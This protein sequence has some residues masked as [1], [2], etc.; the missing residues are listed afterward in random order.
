MDQYLHWHHNNSRLSTLRIFRP[1][2]NHTAGVATPQEEQW[3]AQKDESISRYVA[4]VE[5]YLVNDFIAQTDAPTIADFACYCEF[6]QLEMADQFDFTKYPKVN[7]WMGR[8]KKLPFH[9]DVHEDLTELYTKNNL[10][11]RSD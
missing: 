10:L 9:D 6:D 8:M 11:K 2:M 3:L 7:A 4:I 1:L 5:A